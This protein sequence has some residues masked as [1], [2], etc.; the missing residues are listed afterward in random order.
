MEPQTFEIPFQPSS[1]QFGFR[2]IVAV[3]VTKRV[4]IISTEESDEQR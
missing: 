4:T 2:R 3:V 1:R